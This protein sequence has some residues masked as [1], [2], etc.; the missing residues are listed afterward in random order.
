MIPI[1]LLFASLWIQWSINKW[2]TIFFSFFFLLRKH[3]YEILDF[4]KC[5]YEIFDFLFLKMHI[6]YMFE[7]MNAWF[8]KKCTYEWFFLKKK[9]FYECMIFFNAYMMYVWMNF[10]CEKIHLWNFGLF[11]FKNA[12][13][14]VWFF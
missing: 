10:F 4:F 12:F 13:M 7:W 11:L 3:I 8:F 14:N 2:L 1:L 5:I 9:C 6:W